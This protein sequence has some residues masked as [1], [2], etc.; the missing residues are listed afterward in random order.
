MAAQG[1]GA[2]GFMGLGGGPLVATSRDALEYEFAARSTDAGVM[3]NAPIGRTEVR[4]PT[5]RGLCG[6]DPP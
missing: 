2:R 3:V 5:S 1:R 6:W 4:C